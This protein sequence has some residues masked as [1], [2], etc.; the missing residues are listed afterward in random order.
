MDVVHDKDMRE[1]AGETEI[2][3]VVH[4]DWELDRTNTVDEKAQRAQQKEMA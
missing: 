3:R 2:S 4:P 1:V